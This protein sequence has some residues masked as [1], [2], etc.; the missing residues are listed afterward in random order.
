M[1]PGTAVLRVHRHGARPEQPRIRRPPGR[2]RIRP[3][4]RARTCPARASLPRSPQAALRGHRASGQPQ[5]PSAL[6]RPHGREGDDSGRRAERSP[7]LVV[8]SRGGQADV[9]RRHAGRPVCAQRTIRT[10]R[11]GRVR[12]KT[13]RCFPDKLPIGIEKADTSRFVFLYLVN[14]RIP[15][16]FR[17]FLIRHH[18]LF[19]QAAH[20]DR[21]SARAAALQEVRRALQSRAPRGA[22]DAR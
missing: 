3:S 16:D 8:E 17:Q 13:V 6:D 19:A 20:V 12:A 2:S 14:R 15:V 11:S 1:L 21:A 7:L 10:S 9:L 22:L 4:H 18:D 5:S